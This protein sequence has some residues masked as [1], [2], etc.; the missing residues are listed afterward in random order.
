MER[1]ILPPVPCDHRESHLREQVAK[2]LGI[3]GG[4]FDEF[5]A[6]GA[7][8]ILKAQRAELGCIGGGGSHV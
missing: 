7:H 2:Q 4:I 3:G 5:E 1:D 8:R 6:I